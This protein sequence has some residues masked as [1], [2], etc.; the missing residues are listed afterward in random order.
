MSCVQNILRDKIELYRA[1]ETSDGQ[2]GRT[3]SFFLIA[4]LKGRIAIMET[5]SKTADY[6]ADQL[7]GRDMYEVWT[8]DTTRPS[9]GDKIK[10]KSGRFMDVLQSAYEP[11]YKMNRLFVAQTTV[12]LGV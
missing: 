11:S 9:E 10:D 5:G 3:E 1:T 4:T 8:N 2:G 12:G 6:F 7:A